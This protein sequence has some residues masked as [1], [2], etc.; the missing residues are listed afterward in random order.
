MPNIDENC[1]LT[2]VCQ[3]VC[4]VERKFRQGERFTHCG[5]GHRMGMAHFW[6]YLLPRPRRT[7]VRGNPFGRLIRF[8]RIW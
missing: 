1:T 5:R 4:G 3:C 6:T 2:G 8:F 7:R